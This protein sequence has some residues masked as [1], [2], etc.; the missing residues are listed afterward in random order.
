MAHAGDHVGNILEEKPGLILKDIIMEETTLYLNMY[1]AITQG[2]N[3][4]NI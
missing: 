4:E 3:G 1:N 2:S